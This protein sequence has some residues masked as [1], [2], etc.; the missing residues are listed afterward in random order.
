M[1]SNKNYWTA[2]TMDGPKKGPFTVSEVLKLVKNNALTDTS[3]VWKEHKNEWVAVKTI[4]KQLRES[5]LQKHSQATKKEAPAVLIDTFVGDPGVMC[6]NCWHRFH[7]EDLKFIAAHES[8]IGDPVLG[9]NAALRFIPNR[10]TPNGNAIDPKGAETAS[11]ACPRCHLSLPRSIIDLDYRVV[12]I[13]G[14][15][16]SGKTYLLASMIWQA[17]RQL[18][19]NFKMSFSDGDTTANH[20]IRENERTLFVPEDENSLVKLEKTELEGR[21]YNTVNINN[22]AMNYLSP[23]SF[24]VEPITGHPAYSQAEKLRKLLVLYDNA[25]EHFEP[26]RSELQTLHLAKSNAIFFIFDPSS[27]HA[28]RDKMGELAVKK[29][30][31]QKYRLGQ[32]IIFTEACQRIRK[33]MGLSSH[34]TISKPVYVIA[35][36]YDAWRH[37]LPLEDTNPFIKTIEGIS[38]LDTPRISRVS[39]DLRT[40]FVDLCPELVGMV[41]AASDNVTYIPV[42]AL[43]TETE[44]HPETGVS[45]MVRP[46]NVKPFWATVPL[47]LFFS[48]QGYILKPKQEPDQIDSNEF[49][50]GS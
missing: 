35:T 44:T 43:G 37:L 20:T 46:A 18:M 7:V 4:A 13:V 38:G 39:N 31:S 12:S 25:G 11:V 26:G 30:S 32:D 45:G 16:Q 33:H 28:F 41:E 10:F 29:A 2:E 27:D 24:V 15:P 6:I 19:R 23:F 49:L 36:K 47:L 42:S 17:R 34:S 8:L 22:Q 40:L 1:K 9:E 21:L 50:K 48:R 3:F 14:A 5:Q